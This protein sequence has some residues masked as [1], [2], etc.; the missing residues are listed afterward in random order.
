MT[1]TLDATYWENRHQ[2]KDTPWKLG[3][4]SP[5]FCRFMEKIK[6]KNVQILIPGAGHAEDA[7][8]LQQQGFKRV[9]IC[10]ISESAIASMKEALGPECTYTFLC[11]DFFT[12][13]G[14][15][16]YIFEQT[17]FC[18]LPKE[19]RKDYVMKMHQ[20]L[21]DGGTLFGLLFAT[22]FDKTGPPFGGDKETYRNLFSAVFTI[23]HLDICE[24]S[25]APRMGN[26]LFII[27]K[28]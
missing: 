17:F 1:P 8:Y 10:D 14:S 6:D 21:K 22:E 27:C 18:A 3:H 25:V 23:E 11:K 15:Y 4:A 26:E 16:D 2:N 28:K 9:T 13:A 19:L 12:I 20:L 5:A 24:Y 7:L